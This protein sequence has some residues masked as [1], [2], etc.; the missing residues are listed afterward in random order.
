MKNKSF[1]AA[2]VFIFSSSTH[3]FAIPNLALFIPK[4]SEKQL[5]SN[6]KNFVNQQIETIKSSEV[7]SEKAKSI[8]IENTE[9]SSSLND[10]VLAATAAMAQLSTIHL[11]MNSKDYTKEQVVKTKELSDELFLS[12]E[13]KKYS[14]AFPDHKK[15]NE[16]DEKVTT[17]LT[18]KA[19]TLHNLIID[20][21]QENAAKNN[22]ASEE[23]TEEEV[24]EISLEENQEKNN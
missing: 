13:Y 20:F 1:L 15:L 14:D 16:L 5:L 22:E 21:A 8:L 10:S 7:L 3:P 6:A 23:K 12:D 24:S 18:E 17:F 2:A 19:I 11:T 4:T 9:K